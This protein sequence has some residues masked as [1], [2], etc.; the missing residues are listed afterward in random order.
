[1]VVMETDTM[2]VVME[3]TTDEVCP[4]RAT[5]VEWVLL[6]WVVHQVGQ[7]VLT[8]FLAVAVDFI[9]K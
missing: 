8:F 9:T 6:L 3:T 4:V 2:M 7:Y 1:M 5:M